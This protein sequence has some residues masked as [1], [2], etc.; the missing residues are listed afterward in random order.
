MDV[1]G[2]KICNENVTYGYEISS[3]FLRVRVVGLIDTVLRV[4]VPCVRLVE[5]I[6][7]RRGLVF[8]L[9]NIFLEILNLSNLS[10]RRE[11]KRTHKYI[12]IDV[13]L[14]FCTIAIF[15]SFTTNDVCV[16]LVA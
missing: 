5:H 16:R 13:S 7:N 9:V 4:D 10:R 14:S 3:D 2:R 12:E 6:P 1:N 8:K 15:R 11:D